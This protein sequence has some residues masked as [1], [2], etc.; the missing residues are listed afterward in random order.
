MSVYTNI[1]KTAKMM[2]L[3]VDTQS[4]PSPEMTK[5]PEPKWDIGTVLYRKVNC[6]DSGI[7][8]GYVIRTGNA[9]TYLVTWAD[10]AWAE[11]GEIE[12]FSFELQDK[13]VL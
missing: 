10:V 3:S 11:N 9:I 1:E 4:C 12:H 8:T 5:I 7:L 6:E 13:K 2:G